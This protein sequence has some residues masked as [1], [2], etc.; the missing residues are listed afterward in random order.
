VLLRAARE[1]L[2]RHPDLTG[3]LVVGVLGGLSGTGLARAGQLEELAAE[4]G[5]S[6][7]VRFLPPVDRPTL[8]EWYRAADLVTVPSYSESFGLVAVEAQACGTPVVAADV[9]GLPFT[10][11]DAGL[12]VP[13][14]GT[15]EWADAIESLLLHRDR[16]AE[17][18]RRAVAHAAGFGWD[19]TTERLLEVYAEARSAQTRSPVADGSLLPSVATTVTP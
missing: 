9:G 8:V 2:D 18:S 19:T 12:L 1:L 6:A 16:R 10:V 3:E 4:L 14:H 15:G 11:G 17:L 5:I 13:T 7:S